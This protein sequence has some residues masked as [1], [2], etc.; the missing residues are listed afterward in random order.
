[1]APWSQFWPSRRSLSRT[2]IQSFA[3]RLKTQLTWFL[4]QS[5]WTVE[6]RSTNTVQ[7]HYFTQ[8][9]CIFMHI[10]CFILWVMYL[11]NK[12][13]LNNTASISI[14]LLIMGSSTKR[15]H[16]R[17][18]AC[19]RFDREPFGY[20]TFFC[21]KKTKNLKKTTFANCRGVWNMKNI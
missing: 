12:I 11:R 17:Q 16:A 14:L 20:F 8:S 13:L 9:V 3:A 19:L 18:N 5:L 15:T 2:F 7:M 4:C 6:V 21:K 1:M 10:E